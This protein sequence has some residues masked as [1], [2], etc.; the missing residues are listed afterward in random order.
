MNEKAS[1]QVE[2]I[3]QTNNTG[4]ITCMAISADG[5]Y[6][7]TGS[8]DLV[9]KL[10]DRVSGHLLRNFSG[11]TQNINT[12]AFSA[13]GVYILAG[14]RY[15]VV[16]KWET[17]TGKCV[18]TFSQCGNFAAMCFGSNNYLWIGGE[19]GNV[20]SFSEEKVQVGKME[21]HKNVITSL[22]LS[23]DEKCLLTGSIDGTVKIWDISE[24]REKL[25]SSYK[26][27]K[28]GT[29]VGLR[30]AL[31][32]A[33]VPK[34]FI[35]SGILKDDSKPAQIQMWEID[36]GNKKVNVK[37]KLK[38]SGH[39]GQIHAVAVSGDGKYLACGGLDIIYL[40][41]LTNKDL[42]NQTP[43]PIE[44]E[45]INFYLKA[46]CFSQNNDEHWI[47]ANGER[48]AIS[49][50]IENLKTATIFKSK[51]ETGISY[52][53]AII[54][55][56]KFL[57]TG[58]SNNQINIWDLVSGKIL[59]PLN[60][61]I[62]NI[63]ELANVPPIEAGLDKYQLIRCLAVTIN[64]T[65]IAYGSS[66]G[67]IALWNLKTGA[68][69]KG[70]QSGDYV[71]NLHFSEDG[72]FLTFGC[73]NGRM[74]YWE[75][76]KKEPF[77]L[78]EDAKAKRV[79]PGRTIDA[80]AD[81]S[82]LTGYLIAGF[83]NKKG[84]DLALVD[85]R[86]KNKKYFF[87]DQGG[88]LS[89]LRISKNSKYLVTASEYVAV[90]NIESAE[91]LQQEPVWQW[92]FKGDA[93]EYFESG[94][95]DISADGR[96]VVCGSTDGLIRLWDREQVDNEPIRIF[97]GHESNVTCVTL[98][99][100]EKYIISSSED[101]STRIWEWQ[102]EKSFDSKINYTRELVKLLTVNETDSVAVAPSGLFDATP[103]GMN[104]LHF[105]AG[106]EVI[107]LEQLKGRY[108]QPGLL[109]ALMKFSN[110]PLRNVAEL[111]E[112]AFY[113]EIKKMELDGIV[114]QVELEERNG[115]I[116]RTSLRINNKEVEADINSDRK[117]SFSFSLSRYESYFLANQKNVISIRCWNKEDWLPGP[118][119]SVDY[120]KQSDTGPVSPPA[121]HCL[122]VGTSVYSNKSLS[123]SFPD[124]DAA[125]ICDAVE[126]VGEQL[127]KEHVY[128]KLLTTEKADGSN[129]SSK[130]NIKKAFEDIAAKASPQDVVIIYFTGHGANY[131]DGKNPQFYYLTYET[132]SGDLSDSGVRKK[133]SIS[134]EEFVEW[135]NNIKACKQVL[136]FDTC[137]SGKLLDSLKSKD[138]MDSTSERALERMKD[139][140][141][142]F[143]LTGS[144]ADKVSYEATSYGQG[145]LTYS[146]LVGMR[147]AGLDHR[148][149]EQEKTVDVLTLFKFSVD[150]VERISKEF[151][152]EQKPTFR[153]PIN[154]QSFDIGLAPYAVT[155]KIKVALPKPVFVYS[156]L[157]N[158]DGYMDNLNLSEMLDQHLG[159]S[160]AMGR[161]PAALLLNVQKFPGA[162]AVRGLYSQKETGYEVTGRVYKDKD[163]MGD[164]I[165]TG[166]AMEDIIPKLGREVERLTFANDQYKML[167]GEQ[168]ITHEKAI[169]DD[170]GSLK[171]D[172]GY[173]GYN[174]LFIDPK[175]N[176]TLPVIG[177]GKENDVVKL[178]NSKETELK[179]QSYSTVQCKSRKF[180]FF[181]ACNINGAQFLTAARVGVFIAD[182]R[183][184]KAD[185]WGDELY[186][187]Q[188][189]DGKTEKNQRKLYS[190]FLD[191][192][193]MSKRE[194]PQWGTTKEIAERGA[195]LTFFFTNAVP[196]VGQ[197]NRGLWGSL[198]DY[199]LKEASAVKRGGKA[200]TPGISY[201]IN[202]FTGPVFQDDDPNLEV[203]VGGKKTLA[204]IPTLFWKIAYYKK[205]SDGKLYYVGF[206]LGQKQL[207]KEYMGS[208]LK[209][210]A[211]VAEADEKE[212]FAD[213]KDKEVFQTNISFIEK[214]TSLSF[215]KAI[216]PFV[217]K[218]TGVQII[219]KVQV[220]KRD[221][222]GDDVDYDYD[223]GGISLGLD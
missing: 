196:Q 109:S 102:D 70:F 111:T 186:M 174:T 94:A 81:M 142:S 72:K 45:R 58:G 63:A 130:E 55:D 119:Q 116:G 150:E 71:L 211:K 129:L 207:L 219:E 79:E 140:T 191:R 42:A 88:Y 85:T 184:D 139:R 90:W 172:T 38:F 53:S 128:T 121:L 29:L 133:T 215:F 157:M 118:L 98:S 65:V 54:N 91:N 26:I 8:I 23:H 114:L 51:V 209:K 14:Q 27:A 76:E 22:C 148:T 15:G 43:V 73:L 125:S 123:L 62:P 40:W 105:V 167:D 165:V 6:L 138:A 75:W 180:P 19:D 124:Q 37:P 84:K 83:V 190:N 200:K 17:E 80:L 217:D 112:P 188:F 164:F 201:N 113:P 151:A 137:H 69:L 152:L 96:Y 194:D 179:Y 44:L 132:L 144:A 61:K 99:P 86:N 220:Q 168:L 32:P 107:E 9:V 21:A 187:Y 149:N 163:N 56:G 3:V 222:S 198:E 193:H 35:A 159:G 160:I 134:S 171:K 204:K 115:G 67:F 213:F 192:G 30:I 31:D 66:N 97:K 169:S 5:R 106:L 89:V 145:L 28:P 50:K 176:I 100:D 68:Y 185:Q 203:E 64:N 82:S 92:T 48:V 158:A 223:A 197:L 212:L 175:V 136:I 60:K 16:K 46:L 36:N 33:I 7:A 146:L 104:A 120:F 135:I 126:L 25:L 52:A 12:V 181:A 155:E 1:I 166:A 10:W 143:V 77:F 47:T 20:L 177:G 147:G 110:A 173:Y 189:D 95:L 153:P 24:E 178:V 170:M 182:T 2:T 206:L 156:N 18:S 103:E 205:L 141:G 216:D 154:V 34:Y 93:D 202:V 74:G 108:W 57:V 49:W 161:R 221:I 59:L 127:F 131:D 199:I 210:E 122:F 13:D 162:H 214:L 195:R 41:D 39:E 117:K 11:H 208:L 78:P 87:P 183:I 218:R 101:S 4:D